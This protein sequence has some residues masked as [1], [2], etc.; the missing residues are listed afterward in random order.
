MAYYQQDTLSIASRTILAQLLAQII[1]AN[2][3]V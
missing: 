1:S 3:A 2:E